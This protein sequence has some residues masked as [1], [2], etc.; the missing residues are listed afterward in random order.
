MTK[1]AVP[2]RRLSVMAAGFPCCA[3]MQYALDELEIPLTW[4]PK[5]REVGISVLDGGESNILLL[6]CPWRGNKLPESL[7]SEWFAELERRNIDPCGENIPA[8]F[9]DEQW[10][11]APKK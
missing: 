3:Q 9:L 6:F 7:R 11:A 4:T 1:P 2:G 10:Y 8:E 5:F